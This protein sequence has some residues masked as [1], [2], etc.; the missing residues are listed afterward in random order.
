MFANAQ[1]EKCLK[2]LLAIKTDFLA[3]T[4]EHV[5][6]RIATTQKL[7]HLRLAQVRMSKCDP[8]LLK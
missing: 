8:A 1:Y 6:R 3:R 4:L 2:N 5:L 7:R